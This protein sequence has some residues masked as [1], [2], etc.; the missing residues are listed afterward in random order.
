MGDFKE[1]PDIR[2]KRFVII[3]DAK[4]IESDTSQVFCDKMMKDCRLVEYFGA[5][6]KSSDKIFLYIEY[7]HSKRISTLLKWMKNII[8]LEYIEIKKLKVEKKI[9]FTVIVKT[10]LRQNEMPQY[11]HRDG[12]DLEKYF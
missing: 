6:D 11:W 5:Y 7:D 3:I 12:I 9:L 2:L 8:P 10:A 4:K 1:T